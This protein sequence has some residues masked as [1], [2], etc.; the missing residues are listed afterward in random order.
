MEPLGDGRFAAIVALP[1]RG[2][3][4]ADVVVDA[5]SRHFA[6]TKRLFLQ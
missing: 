5:G 6:V 3:W 1:V 4:D 2:N